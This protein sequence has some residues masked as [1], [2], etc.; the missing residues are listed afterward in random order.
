[1]KAHL[2]VN[3]WFTSSG[4]ECLPQLHIFVT[5][6]TSPIIQVKLKNSIHYWRPFEISFYLNFCEI[7]GLLRQNNWSKS[8]L[9][10]L[11]S[12]HLCTFI[13]LLIIGFFMS[14]TALY[15][16]YTPTGF[17]SQVFSVLKVKL[18]N[19][20]NTFTRTL[21]ELLMTEALPFSNLLWNGTL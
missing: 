20:K 17:H 3:M 10:T 1:M 6:F 15:F 12:W 13:I 8:G 14:D 5:L 21:L 4:R 16:S 2:R 18:R 9:A 11:P 7:I 19:T